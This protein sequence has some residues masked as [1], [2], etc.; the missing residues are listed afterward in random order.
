MVLVCVYRYFYSLSTAL[1][2]EC[3]YSIFMN[4]KLFNEFLFVVVYFLFGLANLQ[5]THYYEQ[6]P[7]T[8]QGAPDSTASFIGCMGTGT[9]QTPSHAI[10]LNGRSGW[11]AEG[12]DK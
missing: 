2:R 7:E 5:E 12:T 9:G 4:M 3:N 6:V 8:I 1:H 11:G 10:L